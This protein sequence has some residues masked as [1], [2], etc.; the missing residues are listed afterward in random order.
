MARSL[1]ISAPRC[2][3]MRV[4]GCKITAETAHPVLFRRPDANDDQFIVIPCQ[5]TCK[6]VKG[7]DPQAHR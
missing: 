7:F 6:A 5:L 4:A 1:S 3:V 2:Q